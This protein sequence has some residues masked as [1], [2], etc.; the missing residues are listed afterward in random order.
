MQMREEGKEEEVD[1]VGLEGVMT[2]SQEN[3][4]LVVFSASQTAA[5]ERA[6]TTDGILSSS[7][8]VTVQEETSTIVMHVI[9]E[10]LDAVYK[11]INQCKSEET[12]SG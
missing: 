4:D 11:C 3:K 9:D 10:V 6:V 7:P 2:C 1:A 5:D 12:M 8:V